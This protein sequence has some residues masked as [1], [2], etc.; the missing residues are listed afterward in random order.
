MHAV[1]AVNSELNI[2]RGF[3]DPYTFSHSAFL[4]PLLAA[5]QDAD[6]VY[7]VMRMYPETLGGMMSRL[8]A[9]GKRL[10]VR[11]IKVYAAEL[12]CA[13]KALHGT[14]ST[15]HGDLNLKNV[16]VSPSGHLC[17]ADFGSSKYTNKPVDDCKIGRVGSLL[18]L[19]PEVVQHQER[20][21]FPGVVLDVWAF[22][23]I[24]LEMFEGT[25]QPHFYGRE[26][27]G[28]IKA[29]PDIYERVGREDLL[30]A[31]LID[32]IVNRSRKE[33]GGGGGCITA[34]VPLR[35][36]RLP[37]LHTCLYCMLR[38]FTPG[39]DTISHCRT[40]SQHS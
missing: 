1:R 16:L 23:M 17:L 38:S 11:E 37:Y 26:R 25:G 14:H 30:A 5:F 10:S 6:N 31:N 18:Y 21:A 22:G 40:F 13:L 33:R 32:L 3:V 28:D 35:N 7:F 2:L 36:M 20:T 29:V 4:T 12:L 15:V 9:E 8:V 19:D 27:N 34:V 39:V 24:L